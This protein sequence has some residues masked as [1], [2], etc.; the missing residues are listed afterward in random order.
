M[1]GLSSSQRPAKMFPGV[2]VRV[3]LEEVST[4]ISKP[5]NYHS[6]LCRWVVIQSIKGQS[7][8]KR[9]RKGEF[10]LCLN[11][12]ICLLASN[13]GAPGS[14]VC[15]RPGVKLLRLHSHRSQF[16][17]EVSSY[18]HLHYWFC[19][20]GEPWLIH[21]P[22]RCCFLHRQLGTQAAA[23]HSSLTS[24]EGQQSRVQK[25]PDLYSAASFSNKEA[26]SW[27]PYICRQSIS[28]KDFARIKMC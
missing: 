9:Q 1:T 22:V 5:S 26:T 21:D 20:S 15:R 16:V 6:H 25:I 19:F 7:R 11:W 12:D 17:Q 3:F 18:T 8:T 28:L 14:P 27:L 2:S 23:M 24:D 13:I 4:G 10:A